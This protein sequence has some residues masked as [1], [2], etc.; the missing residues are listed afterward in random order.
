[1]KKEICM[2]IDVE[3]LGDRNVI[4][5]EAKKIL[6]RKDLTI[7]VQRKWNVKTNVISVINATRTISKSFRKYMSIVPGKH[8]IN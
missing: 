6:K 7:E 3:I 1:M 5:K 2:L 8:K 4:K